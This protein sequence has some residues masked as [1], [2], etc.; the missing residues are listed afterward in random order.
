DGD[1]SAR[2]PGEWKNSAG[3]VARVFNSLATMLEELSCEQVRVANEI[4]TQ[5]DLGCTMEVFG[6]YG[7]WRE[8]LDSMNRMSIGLTV[9][10][11]RTSQFA[12]VLAQGRQP[13]DMKSEFIAGEVAE[14]Q[15]RLNAAAERLTIDSH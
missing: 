10:L 8:M 15:S 1:F 7:K 4:G 11:R 3:M 12:G 14:M 5:G 13:E 9:E 2:L 6:I